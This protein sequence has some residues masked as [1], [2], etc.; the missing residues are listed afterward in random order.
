MMR[1]N[2]K[3]LNKY[4]LKNF[5]RLFVAAL[6]SIIVAYMLMRVLQMGN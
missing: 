3:E 6:L 4:R 2:I 5:V 1:I